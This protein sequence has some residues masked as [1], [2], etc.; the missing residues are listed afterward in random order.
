ML[1]PNRLI[2]FPNRLARIARAHEGPDDTP[3]MEL[4]DAWVFAEVDS[5]LALRSWWDAP[6]GSKSVAFATY[7]AALDREEQAAAVLAARFA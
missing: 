1:S 6:S 7:L 5:K 2:P 4:W 3:T